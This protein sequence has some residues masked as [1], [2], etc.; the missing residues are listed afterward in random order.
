[1]S[2]F[3]RAAMVVAAVLAMVG[4]AAAQTT[5][6]PPSGPTAAAPPAAEDKG[7]NTGRISLIAGVDWT[8]AY[9][10]R[11]IKQETKDAIFQPYG[12][13]GLK[14]VE[15]AGPLTNLTLSGGIW[16]SLHW[17]PTGA[18]GDVAADPR[19]WYELDAY[20]KLTATLLEDWSAGIIY[21]AY[22]SPNDLF[23][24]VQEV[25]LSLGF[26][27]SKLLGAF[28]LNPSVLVAFETEGQADAGKH[29]GIYLQLGVAP[30]IT[31]FDKAAYP[32]T[33]ALPVTLGLSAKDYYEFGGSK[34][35]TFGYVAWGPVASIPL[36]FVPSSFGKWQA[37]AGVQFLHL[38]T[39][40]E[41]VNDGDSFQAIGTV[42]ISLTY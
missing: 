19:P 29:K 5:P 20:A 25:A 32:L 38:G 30:S 26:N 6:A 8:T 9:F 3:A 1:M 28:A 2:A 40:L 39:T 13:I 27:D 31:L 7:P 24:T 36:A 37:K 23:G 12:E 42:G 4:P 35:P 22:T 16:N 17:G 34:N 41:K 18:G 11:G 21:T 33:L 14:L 15:S 10:F